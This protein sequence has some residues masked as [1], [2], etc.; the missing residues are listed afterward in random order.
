MMR[1][2][3]KEKCAEEPEASATARHEVNHVVVVMRDLM[4][5][6]R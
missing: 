6:K 2:A 4:S 1:D 3:V 5:R